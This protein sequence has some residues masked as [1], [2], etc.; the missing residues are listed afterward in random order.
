MSNLAELVEKMP[1]EPGVYLMKSR[2]GQVVYVG[3]AKNL[4][5]RLRSYLRGSGDGRERIKFLIPRVEEIDF[6]ATDTEKEALILENNLIKKHKPRYNVNF[7]DDKTYV[8]LRIN[9]KEQWPRLSLVRQR[10][11]DGSLYFGPY[12]SAHAVRETIRTIH[13]IFPIRSCSDNVFRNRTRP[14]LYHEIGRCVAPCVEGYTTKEAYSELVGQVVMLLQGRSEEL[15]DVLRQRM[16]RESEM[17]NF[18]EAGRIYERILAVEKTVERQKVTSAHLADNDLFGFHREGDKVEIARLT[19]RGGKLI[20][21]KNDS[22][23]K[24]FLP[25]G[26]ILASYLNQ[27]YSADNYIPDEIL[28]PIEVEE[29][30][31]LED[32]LSERRGKRV[33]I[34]SPKR[35]EKR[36][37]LEMA[38]KNAELAFKKDHDTARVDESV[39]EELQKKLRL[40][41]LPRTI[42]CFDISDIKGKMAVGSMVKFSM[43]AP[44][45]EGYKRF[46]IRTVSGSDDYA[47]MYEVLHRH[48]RRAINEGE[49]PDLIMVD[50]GKGQLNVALAALKELGVDGPDIVSI[51]KPGAV[52]LKGLKGRGK[53]DEKIYLPGRKNPVIFGSSSAALFLLKRVRDESHR[54][55]I[56]YHKLLRKKEELHSAL[57]DIQGVGRKR[58][59]ALLKHFGSIKKIADATVEELMACPEVTKAVAQRIAAFFKEGGSN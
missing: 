17:L 54:F 14:C 36:E 33:K 2:S 49:L 40:K 42:E 45:K 22:F 51:A 6:I 47:M 34:Y 16:L 44:D 32:Y 48:Y 52:D 58:R 24:Q 39:I 27:F 56:T 57:E 19:V 21:G 38:A 15:I 37:L 20:G 59:E 25:D 53:S 29:A 5:N 12:S 30:A 28:I 7:R 35:G 26:E 23:S 55:A 43:G 3:K 4:R 1:A 41:K 8:S 50:G 11:K 31:A 10:R 9:L 18:E 46:K 13:R